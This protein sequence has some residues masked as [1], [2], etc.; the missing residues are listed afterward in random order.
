MSDAKAF[1]AEGNLNTRFER[2]HILRSESVRVEEDG[3]SEPVW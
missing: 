1:T 3:N 2:D